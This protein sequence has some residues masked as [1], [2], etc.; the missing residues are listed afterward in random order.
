MILLDADVVSELMKWTPA[1]GVLAWI[2]ATPG[3]ALFVSTVTQAEIFN[4]LALMPPGER[5]DAL[6]S[7]ARIAFETHFRRRILPFDS[8]AVEAF[9]ALASERRQ[10]GRPIALADAQI[11]AIARSRRAALATRHVADFEGCG[12]EV[13]NP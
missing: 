7:A 9:A 11:A 3:A 13:L 10:S 5:R 12:V 8:D 6:I 1:P 4:G 2:D